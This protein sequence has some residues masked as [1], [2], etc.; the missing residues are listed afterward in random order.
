MIAGYF[1]ISNMGFSKRKACTVRAA[2]E[3]AIQKSLRSSSTESLHARR[4]ETTERLNQE[5]N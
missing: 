3:A 5:K 4:F 1:G 2:V